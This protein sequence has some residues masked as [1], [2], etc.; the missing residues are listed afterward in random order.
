[1]SEDVLLIHTEAHITT[2]TLNRPAR[3]NALNP[4]LLGQLRETLKRLKDDDACRVVCLTGAGEKAFCAGA[5]LL[6]SMSAQHTDPGAANLNFAHLLQ[7]LRT[8]PKPLIARVNGHAL[9]GGFG[10]AL[11]CDIIVAKKGA[12]L[13]TPEVKV[14]L[15]PMMIAPLI[16][17]QLPKKQAY[18]LMLSGGTFLTEEAEKWG[19]F[20]KVVDA[21]ELDSVVEA[22]GQQLLKGAPLAQQR[23]KRALQEIAQMPFEQAV[24]QL[25][26][27]LVALLQTEDAAEG[28]SAFMEKRSPTW[29]AK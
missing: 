24:E 17:E 28:I 20:H 4:S 27:Q 2:L 13:G 9:G 10:I 29:Q 7:D 12:K 23:G 6:A 8:F 22:L 15:F 14:G 25:S 3:R 11:A 1:M 5:D 21:E 19:L 16:L 18:E 26:G